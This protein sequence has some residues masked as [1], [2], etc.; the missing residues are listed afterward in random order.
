[1]I[2]G[3]EP[4]SFG[5]PFSEDRA[6]TPPG[7][8]RFLS[9]MNT[10]LEKRH[11]K[12]RVTGR[13]VA[14]M[15]LSLSLMLFWPLWEASSAYSWFLSLGIVLISYSRFYGQE[16]GVTCPELV[17]FLPAHFGWNLFALIPGSRI[18]SVDELLLKFDGNFGYVEG[19]VGKLVHCH[20]VVLYCSGL[21]YWGMPLAGVFVYLALPNAKLRRRCIIINFLAG[22][23]LFVFFRICPA[24]GPS[25]LIGNAFPTLIPNLT[26]P[27][28]RIIPGLRFNA[29]PSGHFAWALI[30]FWFAFWYCGAGAR[31]GAG[32]YLFLTFL[33]TLGRGEHYVI[34]LIVAVPFAS[35]MW[36]LVDRK[37]RHAGVAM[38]VVFVWCVALREGWALML[39]CAVVWLACV[40]TVVP[41][42]LGQ[43][44]NPFIPLR[45]L[46]CSLK[47][48]LLEP[49][50]RPI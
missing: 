16:Y 29:M 42:G 22:T 1:M 45:S 24:A 4:I 47:A 43:P 36:A 15:A 41:F 39:P 35:C 26:A 32:V 37:W 6:G 17:F 10:L 18:P 25:A 40:F 20:P 28:A 2:I 33:C 27:H 48:V 49:G 3:A 8:S 38:L 9:R 44:V 23:L 7:R 5:K 30:L 13:A 50:R 34:D 46:R 19:L 31:I 21:F 11:A 12:F 14:F